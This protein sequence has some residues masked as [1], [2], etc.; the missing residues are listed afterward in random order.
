M[1]ASRVAACRRRTSASIPFRCSQ[2]SPTASCRRSF[3][4]G[5]TGRRRARLSAS[6]ACSSNGE[7]S[8]VIADPGDQETPHLI[9]SVQ[10]FCEVVHIRARR[11]IKWPG[12]VDLISF[13]NEHGSGNLFRLH[14]ELVHSTDVITLFL[15][16]GSNLLT[17]AENSLLG[18]TPFHRRVGERYRK[19]LVQD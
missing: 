13:S 16:G 1:V 10:N 5:P 8:H 3:R 6:A 18:F 2:R 4:F 12:F 15:N 9:Q 14:P 19:S 7:S 17:H 11:Q